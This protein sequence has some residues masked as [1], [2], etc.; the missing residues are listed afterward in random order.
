MEEIEQQIVSL[1]K[2]LCATISSPLAGR[3][4]PADQPSIGNSASQAGP[5]GKSP[6]RHVVEEATG[7]TIFLG[8]RSDAPLALGCRETSASGLGSRMLDEVTMAQF[9]PRAYP[10]TSLWGPDA[11]VEEVCETLPDEADLNMCV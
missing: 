7:A 6:G 3:S 1:K 11:T 10:F 8:S 4:S 5:Q 9:V 2:D